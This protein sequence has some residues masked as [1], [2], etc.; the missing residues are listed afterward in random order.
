MS[1]PYR[2]T[3]DY[4]SFAQP[5]IQLKRQ[6]IEA[7]YVERDDLPAFE[8]GKAGNAGYQRRT[9]E[10]YE[11]IAQHTG[12]HSAQALLLQPAQ[13][14]IALH[15]ALEVG[16]DPAHASWLHKFFEDE[17]PAKSYG[18]QFRATPANSELPMSRVLR[19]LDRPEIRVERT[20]RQDRG[21]TAAQ[22]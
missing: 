17:D 11:I 4:C 14:P 15:L 2:K 19:E 10:A 16:I 12:L 21:G 22:M 13:A 9:A 3:S 1:G 6:F 8:L 20:D 18:R 5:A 7:Q